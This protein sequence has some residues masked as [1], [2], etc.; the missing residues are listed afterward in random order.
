MC[1]PWKG[2]DN[3]F[4]TEK[5]TYIVSTNKRKKHHLPLLY[6]SGILR[7]Y[8]F[9]GCEI[10]VY[11]YILHISTKRKWHGINVAEICHLMHQDLRLLF[12]QQ[13]PG[14]TTRIC[15]GSEGTEGSDSFLTL[16]FTVKWCCR[17]TKKNSCL[18]KFGQI[19][20]VG[21][22]IVLSFIDMLWLSK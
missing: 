5:T 16:F 13:G 22:L 21:F 20:M 17:H 10:C 19:D 15:V 4:F 1:L 8:Q 7:F 9:G 11:I 2:H 18:A 12:L 3:T 6:Y 14:R